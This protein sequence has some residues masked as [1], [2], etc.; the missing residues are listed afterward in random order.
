MVFHSGQCLSTLPS[1]LHS[2]AYHLHPHG[3]NKDLHP[4]VLHPHLNLLRPLPNVVLWDAVQ[5]SN[6]I[7]RGPSPRH[8]ETDS[9]SVTRD[10]LL[11]F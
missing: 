11:F 7:L 8:G 2:H 4:P 9:L 5:T 6:Q 1:H 10:Y 3:D